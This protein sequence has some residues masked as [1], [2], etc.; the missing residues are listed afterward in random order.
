N[1]GTFLYVPPGVAVEQP[2]EI[3]HDLSDGAGWG[4]H[5]RALIVLGKGSQA[6]VVERF[7][8]PAGA[9]LT[10]AVTE[11][12]VGEGAV[13]D[14]YKV[15]EE[16]PEA[17]HVAVT[18]AALSR[19]GRFRTHYVGLGGAL[20]RNEARVVFTGENGEATVNGLYLARGTQHMDNFTV[21]DHA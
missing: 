14:H 10:N 16:G 8:G 7:S 21:I 3:Q 9:Y 18:Q 19:D 5:R 12:V 15:Q 2:V 1:G 20:V 4:W 6:T 13:L 11:A 17:L